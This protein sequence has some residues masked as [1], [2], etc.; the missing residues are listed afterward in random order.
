MS[1]REKIG[2]LP[3]R[4][5][6]L[7]FLYI[8]TAAAVIACTFIFGPEK[9][10]EE[11]QLASS[12]PGIEIP[13]VEE[14][15]TGYARKSDA[16]KNLLA[17]ESEKSRREGLMKESDFFGFEAD[18]KKKKEEPQAGTLSG[19]RA[20]YGSALPE[21]AEQ[22]GPEKK[23][24]APKEKVVYVYR[25]R[26]SEKKQEQA[27]PETA[28]R[29]R[30]G[31]YKAAPGYSQRE[32]EEFI[33]AVLEEN[34]KLR[35]NSQVTFIAMEETE[36]SYGK[37]PKQSLL[38]GYVRFGPDRIEVT[39]NRCQDTKGNNFPV[40]LTGYNENFQ[41]GIKYEGKIDNA[42]QRG[43][44]SAASSGAAAAA[45]AAGRAAGSVVRGVSAALQKEPEIF[46]GKGYRMH[47][48][49]SMNQAR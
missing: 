49:E 7:Y 18:G 14:A 5:K 28:P 10:G 35:D 8:P 6:K 29:S 37:I 38:F 48:K 22:E 11:Q 12:A 47:F 26:P 4:D 16:Y 46:I 44:N 33:S 9:G 15:D 32:E 19:R 27:E 1:I 43:S 25:D 3:D 41:R 24:E 40:Q 45:A 21:P 30:F 36:T 31:V 17:E 20:N 23:P 2:R 42:V 13:G 34:Q 39:V